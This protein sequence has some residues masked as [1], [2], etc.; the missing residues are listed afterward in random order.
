[1]DST[2]SPGAFTILYLHYECFDKSNP[3]YLIRCTR[4]GCEFYV[5]YVPP[6]P[7]ASYDKDEIVKIQAVLRELNP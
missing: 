1:M 3:I 5:K 2:I 7:L 4:C 6:R